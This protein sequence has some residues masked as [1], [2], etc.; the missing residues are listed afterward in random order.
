MLKYIF[1]F[2]TVTYVFA[3]S[4]FSISK[5][6]RG[7]QSTNV[8]RL[9]KSD[10]DIIFVDDS[11]LRKCTH[12]TIYNNKP[13]FCSASKEQDAAVCQKGSCV[14]CEK[15]DGKLTM[16]CTHQIGFHAKMP[17]VLII[18]LPVRP[19]FLK[20]KSIVKLILLSPT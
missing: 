15:Q 5:R 3:Q 19:S 12:N 8:I 11:F 6:R 20:H 17:N 9:E 16:E 10:K 4:T 7:K 2:L 13:L 14:V 18:P 1:T